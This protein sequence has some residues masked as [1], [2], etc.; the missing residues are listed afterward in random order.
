MVRN[1]TARAAILV[2][3]LLVSG[4]TVAPE[5]P[6]ETEIAAINMTVDGLELRDAGGSVVETVRFTGSYH[7]AVASLTEVLG[8]PMQPVG[9]ID[10]EPWGIAPDL[11]WGALALS[12][13]TKNL[14]NEVVFTASLHAPSLGPVALAANEVFIVG[15]SYDDVRSVPGGEVHDGGISPTESHTVFGDA[16]HGWL[17]ISNGLDLRAIEVIAAQSAVPIAG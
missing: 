10:V 7:D 1:L 14:P 16:E 4:C 11:P 12:S 9:A 15:G 13:S 6:A 17:T 8:D 5:P 3:V 2:A